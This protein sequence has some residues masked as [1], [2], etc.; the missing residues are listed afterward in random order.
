MAS[1][2]GTNLEA[3]RKKQEDLK[4]KGRKTRLV[5]SGH[6]QWGKGTKQYYTLHWH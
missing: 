3:L 6:I 5:K 2:S 4:S 1:I